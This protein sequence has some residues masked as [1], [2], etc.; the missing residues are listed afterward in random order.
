VHDKLLDK[1][2]LRLA[3]SVTKILGEQADV[4]TLGRNG[5]S[6]WAKVPQ[7]EILDAERE[8]SSKAEECTYLFVVSSH[9]SVVVESIGCR[10]PHLN[11]IITT[12]SLN[13]KTRQEGRATSKCSIIKKPLQLLSWPQHVTYST[14]QK[15]ATNQYASS[16]LSGLAVDHNDV[17]FVFIQ[18]LFLK[19]KEV[20]PR[21]ESPTKAPFFANK[22]GCTYYILTHNLQK[23]EWRSIVIVE[24][25]STNATIE[26][27]RWVVSLGAKIVHFVVIHMLIIK[28]LDHV[29][30]GVS[31]DSFGTCKQ[32]NSQI[33][34]CETHTQRKKRLLATTSIPSLGNPM[35]MM[36]SVM[37]AKKKKE[38]ESHFSFEY[39]FQSNH[40]YKSTAKVDSSGML[41]AATQTYHVCG[42]AL[43]LHSKD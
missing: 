26:V 10:V 40:L 17:L 33:P 30:V 43:A 9:G 20:K 3:N 21:Q 5:D 11:Y 12:V 4:A 37:S 24:G 14:I 15:A 7:W 16:S 23:V 34:R 31:V 35:A 13:H 29:L 18:I 22:K 25:K 28:E 8:A 32:F 42:M 27:S 38:E 36:R 2:G 41:L 6:L 39:I 19:H 1:Q